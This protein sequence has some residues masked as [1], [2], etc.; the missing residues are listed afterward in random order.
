[1]NELLK[2]SKEEINSLKWNE[3]M[4]DMCYFPQELLDKISNLGY[5]TEQFDQYISLLLKNETFDKDYEWNEGLIYKNNVAKLL[6]QIKYR[7]THSGSF[8]VE[9]MKIENI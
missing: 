3:P 7:T 5:K 1:M 9:I 8:Q 6:I 2:Y 4:W